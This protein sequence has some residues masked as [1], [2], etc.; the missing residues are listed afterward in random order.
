MSS[1]CCCLLPQEVDK[2]ESKVSVS[3]RSIVLVVMKAGSAQG[4]WPRLLYGKG[5]VT[6]VQASLSKFAW[7]CSGATPVHAWAVHR[8]K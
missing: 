3:D 8:S 1:V 5:K 2:E 4:H 7:P 6:N